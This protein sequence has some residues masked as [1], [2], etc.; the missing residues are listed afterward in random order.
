MKCFTEIEKAT[1]QNEN[2]KSKDKKKWKIKTRGKWF[3][4]VRKKRTYFDRP[5]M[6]R[7][8]KEQTKNW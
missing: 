1:Q 6:Q 5:L 4:N 8:T 3:Q 2:T 7:K